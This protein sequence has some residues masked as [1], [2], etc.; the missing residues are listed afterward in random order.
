MT[1]ASYVTTTSDA[2]R[3]SNLSDFPAPPNNAGA[4]TPGTI[5][6]SY[7][8]ETP[9]TQKADPF[10]FEGLLSRPQSVHDRFMSRRTTF[11]GEEPIPPLDL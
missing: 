1:R 4:M 2:S 8:T 11:G 9:D 3:I 7:F 6:Q 10:E 5:L